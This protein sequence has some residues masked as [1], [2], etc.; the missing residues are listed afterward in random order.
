[1]S[2]LVGNPEDRFT[3]KAAHMFF[4]SREQS[5]DEWHTDIEDAILE[6]CKNNNGILHIFVDRASKE[7]NFSF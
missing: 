6:K 5:T 1:M 3:H 4:V 7:V 2:D